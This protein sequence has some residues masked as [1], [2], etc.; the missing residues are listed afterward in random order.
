MTETDLQ[1]APRSSTSYDAV[2]YESFPYRQT[3]P[4]KLATIAALLGLHRKAP[5]ACRVLE[6]GCASGGN[7]LPLAMTYPGSQ[8]LGV[9]SSP[10]QIEQGQAAIDACGIGNAQ[11]L[12]RSVSDI[13]DAFG[14]FDYIIAH[15]LYSWVPN[16][17]Q[18]AIL[19]VCSRN[20]DPDGVA[21]VSYNTLPGWHM[22]GLI[23]D[24]MR[25]HPNGFVDPAQPV[26]QAREM[27]D[28]LGQ[29]LPK[30]NSAYASL[31]HV[32]LEKLRKL[33]DYYILHEYL[34]ETNEPLY[35]HQFV[36]RAQRHQLQ[37]LAE[38]DFSTMAASGFAP[39]VGETLR[40]LAPDIVRQEQLVD[41][42]RNR[43]FRQTLL[44]HAERKVERQI[45]PERVHVLWAS[46]L[47]QAQ[48]KAPD[49]R[50]GV[51]E[52]FSTATGTTITTSN[53]ITKAALMV[54]TERWPQSVAF[55]ELLSAAHRRVHGALSQGPSTHDKQTLANDL[56]YGFSHKLLELHASA[57]PFAARAEGKPL[58]NALA[59]WQAHAGRPVT[60]LRHEV[61]YLT[62]Q[63]RAL[64]PLLDGTR[65]RA[66]LVAAEST[67]TPPQ[68]DQTLDEIA[69]VA[70]L[71]APAR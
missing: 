4:D 65:D 17:V 6:L 67:L 21:Y 59:R 60:N 27:L 31:V 49:L 70:L 34:E 41:F 14:Q 51:L 23:R 36:E 7:L 45:A 61:V 58:V 42:L 5:A 3:H 25:L 44:V 52:K 26:R 63:M 64:L 43:S 46:A 56:L 53:A 48:R 39:Q 28:F 40:R 38:S 15:G 16:A 30:D 69:R 32:D 54:L 13:D 20:L 24:L 62:D 9:D 8:F 12:A 19:R 57:S 29:A 10:V 37:Y 22:H 11:L 50:P 1:S 66:A 71:V 55:T 33:P 68:L 35:F 47:V 2:P 18:D